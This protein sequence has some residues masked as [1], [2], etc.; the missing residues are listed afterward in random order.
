MKNEQLASMVNLINASFAEE[1][2][3][4]AEGLDVLTT[5]MSAMVIMQKYP[6]AKVDSILA[7]FVRVVKL[8]YDEN[9]KEWMPE[10]FN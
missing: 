3:N 9:R 5:V 6:P 8:N 2:I 7:E 4:V 1:S 10:Q